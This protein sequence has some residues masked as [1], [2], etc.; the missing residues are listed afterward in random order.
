[1]GGRHHHKQ[2]TVIVVV[3]ST[4]NTD[5]PSLG[6]Q[7]EKKLSLSFYKIKNETMKCHSNIYIYDQPKFTNKKKHHTTL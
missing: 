6:F 2:K 3:F 5:K 4:I 7:M 1:M